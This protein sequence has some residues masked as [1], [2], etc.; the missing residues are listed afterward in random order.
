[1]FELKIF[2]NIFFWAIINFL[3]LYLIY[4]KFFF[5]RV[6]QFMEK[7][8]QI[9][10]DQ[11]DFAAKSK[12][13][14]IK[15][16]EEYENILAQAHAKANEIVE[17]ATLEAQRQAAEIIENAKLEANRI[18]ENALRQFEIEKKKQI[19]ELKNQFVSIALLAASRVIEKNLNTEENRK[20]V[21]N[22]FDEAGVA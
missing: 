2:E 18:M 6:T 1:M 19:N 21:E 4:K 9:I 8:S 10:Q 12:E 22:I 16:K 5:Q 17:S 13:E 7:R 11:L 3:I 14:A 20:M 15:L